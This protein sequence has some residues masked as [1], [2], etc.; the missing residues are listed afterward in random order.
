MGKGA[1]T[2]VAEVERCWGAAGDEVGDDGDAAAAVA[3]DAA[4]KEGEHEVTPAWVA[5]AAAA[6]DFDKHF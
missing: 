1:E 4:G 2:K 5:A 6:A 3:G